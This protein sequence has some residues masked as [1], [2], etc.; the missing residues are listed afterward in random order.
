[1]ITISD[2]RRSITLN[3]RARE[4]Y[5][6]EYAERHG[7]SDF[8]GHLRKLM[9]D[10][11]YSPEMKRETLRDSDIHGQ[12]AV[13]YRLIHNRKILTIWAD[14]DSFLPVQVEPLRVL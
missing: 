4:A 13:G 3:P 14:P 1:M 8:F 9:T 6:T 12:K 11:H 2:Q 7:R 5:I 10:P